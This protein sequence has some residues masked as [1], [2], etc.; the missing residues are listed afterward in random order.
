MTKKVVALKPNDSLAAL[1]KIFKKHGI[2]GAPVVNGANKPVGVIAESDLL[3]HF[4][5]MPAP[6]AVNLLGSLVFL[7]NP[8]G[9]N[10]KLKNKAAETV[11]GL[12]SSPAITMN[13]N[14]T[15][16]QAIS[17]MEKKRINRLPITGSAGKLTGL[18]TRKDVLRQLSKLLP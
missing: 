16:A 6:R 1:F 11:K 3:K 17:L 7:E 8:A 15:L 4:T 9:F 14:A 18:L 12:M 2:V 5:A 13:E 10:K